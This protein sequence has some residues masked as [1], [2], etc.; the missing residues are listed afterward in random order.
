MPSYSLKRMPLLLRRKRNESFAMK[1]GD[2]FSVGK[3]LK[4]LDI[5][6]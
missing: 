5:D 3:K 4:K 1:K 6:P 2:G